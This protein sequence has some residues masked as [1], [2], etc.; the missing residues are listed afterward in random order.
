MANRTTN[1]RHANYATKRERAHPATLSGA[2]A[3]R[4]TENDRKVWGFR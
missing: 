4:A 3:L 2:P 1:A